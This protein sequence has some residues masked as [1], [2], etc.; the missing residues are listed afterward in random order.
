MPHSRPALRRG[1]TLLELVVALAVLATA[2][3]LVPAV[4]PPDSTGR[5]LEGSMA[6]VPAVLALRAQR[7]A[8]REG[9][10]LVL[11]ITP[12]GAWTLE[13][14]AGDTL[15]LGVLDA[16]HTDSGAPPA[17]VVQVDALGGLRG[18]DASPDAVARRDAQR[19]TPAP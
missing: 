8:V 11:R 17:R 5:T 14:S 2:A 18:V 3:L 7:L 9:R 15:A 19:R 13:G 10:P 1:L 6:G 4:R 12:S 16:P